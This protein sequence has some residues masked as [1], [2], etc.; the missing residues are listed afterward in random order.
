MQSNNANNP[1]KRP[2][3][4]P[5]CPMRRTT[6]M[7]AL[8]EVPDQIFKENKMK[9]FSLNDNV[10]P[11]SVICPVSLPSASFLQSC[12]LCK[13]RLS[14][15]RDIYMYRGDA[16]FCSAECRHQQI[17]MDEK[18]EK[19][20]SESRKMKET[21]ANSVHLHSHNHNQAPAGAPAQKVQATA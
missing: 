6:S 9:Q 7:K 8:V 13:R 2:R 12:F 18:K 10:A 3:P 4:R 1:V 15:A 17:V 5:G 20:I 11:V 16:A 21:A 19:Y 14:P